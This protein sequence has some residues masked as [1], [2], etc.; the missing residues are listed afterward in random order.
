[1]NTKSVGLCL[2]ILAGA[3]SARAGLGSFARDIVQDV[4]IET[5]ERF[6]RIAVGTRNITLDRPACHNTEYGMHYGFDLSTPK[7][8]ALLATTT[9]ALLAG[10]T[11][12]LAGTGTCIAVRETL[13][14]EELATLSLLK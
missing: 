2:V 7:G 8:K 12:Q 9:A 10:K 11:V 14:L 6:A 3:S 5:G 1:M 13:V 4:T